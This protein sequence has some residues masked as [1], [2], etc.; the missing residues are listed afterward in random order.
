MMEEECRLEWFCENVSSHI[1]GRDP[2]GDESPIIEMLTNEMMSNIYVLGPG[3]YD[4]R[5]GNGTR[6]LIITENGKWY[7]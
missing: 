7:R 5:V 4:I 1:G 2:S 3:G 6:T